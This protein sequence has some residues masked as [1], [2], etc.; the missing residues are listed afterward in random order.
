M[1]KRKKNAPGSASGEMHR[2]GPGDEGTIS[3]GQHMFFLRLTQGATGRQGSF[4]WCFS[5]CRSAKRQLQK[6]AGGQTATSL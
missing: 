5:G 1:M 3:G 4:C 6:N 2:K